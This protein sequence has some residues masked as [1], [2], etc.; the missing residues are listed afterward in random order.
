MTPTNFTKKEDTTH[1]HYKFSDLREFVKR[2]SKHGDCGVL[3][4]R[5]NG[6]FS[7][8]KGYGTIENPIKHL[9]SISM[10]YNPMFGNYMSDEQLLEPPKPFFNSDN[11][12]FVMLDFS[13]SN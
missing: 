4:V 2:G 3:I 8:Y 10:V 6:M 7:T 9:H 5:R 1:L 13:K 11:T 12:R